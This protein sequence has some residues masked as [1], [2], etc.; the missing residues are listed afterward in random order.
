MWNPDGVDRRP[1][2]VASLLIIVV[3]LPAGY[4]VLQVVQTLVHLLW[5]RGP[6]LWWQ[7][8]SPWPYVVG[9]P[10]VAGVLVA[11]VRAKGADGHNPLTGISLAPVS[12]HD[13]PGV[14]LAIVLTL[15]G[16]L[17]LGPEAALV[18]TG[19]FLGGVVAQARSVPVKLGVPVGAAAAL[20]SLVVNPV[21][22][23]GMN[24]SSSYRFAASDL[25]PAV[26]AALATVLFLAVV[27]IG[28][29]AVILARGGDRALV[30]HIG[31]GGLIV[32]VVAVVYQSASGQPVHLVLTSGESLIKP[33]VTLGS[34]SLIVWTVLAKAAVYLVCL[35]S[36][37]R[38]GPYFPAMF[39]GAGIG[40]ACASVIGGGIEPAAAAGIIASMTFLAHV[41][42]GVTIALS[43]IIGG[44]VGGVV[45]LPAAVVGGLVGRLIPIP[46]LETGKPEPPG[47]PEQAAEAPA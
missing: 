5:T 15:A 3:C 19:A 26:V 16:G 40:A 39:I 34:A 33:L 13:F 46:R 35:G 38:G 24:I 20:A 10:T 47:H 14:L 4:V 23:G 27:R 43:A 17:A 9:L 30:W 11:V 2:I 22:T 28:A 45:L 41:K 36:G 8:H 44:V 37:F 29:R 1:S 25:L 31:L 12:P 32:G 6:D 18:S 21:L 7:G 42:W